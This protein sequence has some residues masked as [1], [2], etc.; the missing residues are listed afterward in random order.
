MT[1]GET[2]RESL[3]IT[4]GKGVVPASRDRHAEPPW[5]TGPLSRIWRA[6][7]NETVPVR[8]WPAP[9]T[10]IRLD[11]SVGLRSG[12]IVNEDTDADAMTGFYCVST[13]SALSLPSCICV[14]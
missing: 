2:A 7:E 10:R 13:V 12:F 3:E 11:R 9:M 14:S 4:F 1:L 5:H 8:D 6:I